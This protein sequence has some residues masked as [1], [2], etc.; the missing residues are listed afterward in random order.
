MPQTTATTLLRWVS[1]DRISSAYEHY[2][3]EDS[4]RCIALWQPAGTVGRVAVGERGG[5]RGRNMVPGGWGG[6][7]AEHAWTGDGVLRIHVPGQPWSTWRWL[8]PDGWTEHAYVNLEAPWVRTSLGFDTADWILDVIAERDGSHSLKDED[9]LE[10]A[11]ETG[12]FDAAMLAAVDDAR[13][14]AVAAV[15]THAFPFD[16]DW[17][18]WSPFATEA[19]P[20]SP[21]WDTLAIEPRVLHR[22]RAD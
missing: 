19:L 6:T 10:W 14:H 4:D 12:K 20:L 9:E 18:A 1:D 2:V 11:G 22:I 21:G 13:H 3:V 8:T 7:Y 5:P 15:E 16:A 17:D